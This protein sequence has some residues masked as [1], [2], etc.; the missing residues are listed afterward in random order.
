MATT[1]HIFPLASEGK[2][3]IIPGSDFFK[4]SIT[5]KPNEYNKFQLKF[6][7]RCFYFGNKDKKNGRKKQHILRKK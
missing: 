5:L 3:W 4:E 7:E 6:I 2:K 1:N